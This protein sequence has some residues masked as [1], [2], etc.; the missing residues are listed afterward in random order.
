MSAACEA[1][2]NRPRRGS[3]FTRWACPRQQHTTPAAYEA[4]SAAL[5]S[6]AGTPSGV[7]SSIQ[8]R[9]STRR[10]PS[11]NSRAA[12]GTRPGGGSTARH[13]AAGISTVTSTRAVDSPRSSSGSLLV[14]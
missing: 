8:T 9:A 3:A 2:V 5:A 10:T 1:T 6:V 7:L 12:G 14:P 13:L 4:H 11:T